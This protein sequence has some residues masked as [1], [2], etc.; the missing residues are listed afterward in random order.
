[1]VWEWEVREADS[2]YLDWFYRRNDSPHSVAASSLHAGKATLAIAAA[3]LK[4]SF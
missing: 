2:P 4:R 1:M 3:N